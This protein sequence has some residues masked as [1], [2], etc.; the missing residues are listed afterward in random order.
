MYS[1][2]ASYSA[3][4]SH[5]HVMPKSTIHMPRGRLVRSEPLTQGRTT[6]ALAATVWVWANAAACRRPARESRTARPS[7]PYEGD[8]RCSHGGSARSCRSTPAVR[9]ALIVV[10]GRRRESRSFS[11]PSSIADERDVDGR[12]VKHP[13]LVRPGQEDVAALLDPFED[14][15]VGAT[16]DAL[17]RQKAD[18][19]APCRPATIAR[20]FSCQ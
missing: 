18:S 6:S 1:K 9:F 17:R 14:A 3:A 10:T 2:G 12:P 11:V 20:A 4:S 8:G 19:L 13:R 7:V 16:S 15:A 5:R